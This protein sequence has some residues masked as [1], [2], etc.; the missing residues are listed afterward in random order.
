MGLTP[1]VRERII[2]GLSHPCDEL[3][4]ALLMGNVK[5]P[6][7]RYAQGFH[8]PIMKYAE[9]LQALPDEIIQHIKDSMRWDMLSAK[10]TKPIISGEKEVSLLSWCR[11]TMV[12]AATRAYFGEG[13]LQIEPN[14]SQVLSDF[15]DEGVM[16]LISASC[17]SIGPTSAAR[18]RGIGVFAAYFGLPMEQR[19]GEAGFIRNLED[20]YR[21]L[22]LGE[23]DLAA[24]IWVVYWVSVLANPLPLLISFSKFKNNPHF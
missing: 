7:I 5:K 24:L 9:S 18:E 13:L 19:A 15:E 11:E 20:E 21:H 6:L 2:R 17:D 12:N 14:L 16:F 1:A 8:K 3:D 10:Y 22:G 4:T 23:K